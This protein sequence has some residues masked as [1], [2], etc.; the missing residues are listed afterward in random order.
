MKDLNVD[1]ANRKLLKI[2]EMVITELGKIECNLLK[3][4]D[5]VLPSLGNKSLRKSIS[6]YLGSLSMN[7][8]KTK[9]EPGGV[10]FN[11]NRKT[12]KFSISIDPI[13]LGNTL[14]LYLNGIKY[15]FEV[16]PSGAVPLT[17][18]WLSIDQEYITIYDGC[19]FYLR[20]IDP[21][22]ITETFFQNI[23]DNFVFNNKVVLDVGAAFGDSALFFSKRGATV[24]AVEPINF[25]WLV[26][27]LKLNPCLSNRVIPL[28]AAAGTDG[29]FEME[30]DPDAQFDGQARLKGINGRHSNHLTLVHGM[31]ISEIIKAEGFASVDYL[32]SDCKG[33]ESL[34]KVDDFLKVREGVE[35]D[36]SADNADKVMDNLQRAGFETHLTHVGG[37][38]NSSLR[39]NGFIIGKRL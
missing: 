4:G 6:N 13:S 7:G 23:H 11:L 1:L 15:G 2:N 34:F 20:S 24:I 25:N 12:T 26:K 19:V 28:N 27:N 31:S 18:R 30:S 17:T 22:V 3:M 9:I 10:S 8:I 38:N 37:C 32:K 5:I 36:C 21:T 33:C 16:I 14:G 35:I 39:Y 29:D